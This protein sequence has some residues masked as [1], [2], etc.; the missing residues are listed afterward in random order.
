MKLLV[1][2]TERRLLRL[3]GERGL[4][5]SLPERFGA[6]ILVFTPRGR[7][8]IQRKEFPSDLFASLG[9]SR[10]TRELALMQGLEFKWLIVE[11]TPTYTSDGYLMDE[12]Y[13]RWTRT[14]VRN[15]LRS[16]EI[17][18]GVHVEGSAST[19]ELGAGPTRWIRIP[20]P[21]P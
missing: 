9:D 20:L 12:N 3:L 2:P 19:A 17:Q 14:K 21:R 11:G 16:V 1:S 13:S 8:G 18:Q 7:L 15:L 5:S 4:S 6:D 10:L